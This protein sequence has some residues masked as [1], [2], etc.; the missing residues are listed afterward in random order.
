MGL[1]G[2]FERHLKVNRELETR[3]SAVLN[4]SIVQLPF[5]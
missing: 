3:V 5:C 4:E 1:G 2:A